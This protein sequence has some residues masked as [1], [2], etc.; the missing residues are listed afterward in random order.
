MSLLLRVGVLLALLVIPRLA[1]AQAQGTITQTSVSCATS[2]TTLLAANAA[3]TFIK[4]K[5]PNA[6]AAT[7]WFNWTGVAAVAAL[8]S[9][10]LAAGSSIVFYR[11]TG[12]LPR[13]ALTCISAGGSAQSVLLEYQ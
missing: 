11:S 8:P 9:E 2:S 4:V 1:F 10:D 5:V 7:V 12:F 6:A 3:T 13:T